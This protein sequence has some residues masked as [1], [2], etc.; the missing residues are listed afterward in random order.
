MVKT[1]QFRT[2]RF[3]PLI[4]FHEIYLNFDDMS[5]I[6]VLSHVP[7]VD[8][9]GASLHAVDIPAPRDAELA[10]MSISNQRE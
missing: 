10:G 4:Q 6:S 7:N 9:E 5:S 8:I 3:H 1:F 2:S